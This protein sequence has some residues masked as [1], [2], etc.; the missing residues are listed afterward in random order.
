MVVHLKTPPLNWGGG[1]AVFKQFVSRK[2]CGLGKGCR[3]GD[4]SLGRW[5]GGKTGYGLFS[6]FSESVWCMPP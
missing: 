2:G 1:G 3:A 5:V 4:M 6:K